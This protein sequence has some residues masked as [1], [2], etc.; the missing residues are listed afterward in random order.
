MNRYC[1]GYGV[2]MI[3]VISDLSR[4]NWWFHYIILDDLLWWINK[5]SLG[6]ANDFVLAEI[7][8][9]KWLNTDFI[10]PA[11]DWNSDDRFISSK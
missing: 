8:V 4:M 9:L 11:K 3:I 1:Y 10:M 2:M 6:F 7:E 5:C